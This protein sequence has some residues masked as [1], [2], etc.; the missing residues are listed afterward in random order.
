MESSG[1]LPGESSGTIGVLI[2][3]YR[4]PRDL[5][6]CLDALERQTVAPKEVLV[7]I[8]ADDHET[9]SALDNR[10]SRLLPLR[11][12][13]VIEEGVRAARRVGFDACT[14]DFLAIADDDT[15]AHPDWL[16]RIRDHFLAQPNVA[17]VGGRDRC[18]V[19]GKWDDRQKPRVGEIQWFGRLL[20]YNH[21][22]YGPPRQ[23]Q[24]L[25]GA[26]MSFRMS[27]VG[28]LRVDSRLRGSGAQ[29]HEDSIF[30]VDLRRKGYQIIYDPL[31][32]VDHYEGVRDEPRHYASVLRVTDARQFRDLAYNWSVVISR[33]F[34][35]LQ[36]FVFLIWN[37]L[38]GTRVGPGVLQAV[39]FTPSLGIVSWKRFWLTQQGT[40]ESYRDLI[41]AWWSDGK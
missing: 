31:V 23:V 39:R 5:Q 11:I 18:L 26:N 35:P 33:E 10:A 37:F 27:A 13:T 15:A 6:R 22:G 41:G 36:Q 8:R 4:R 7:V 28:D 38:I 9:R 1:D 3:S 29:P 17:G 12:L 24:I 40:Y 19:G 30:C 21:L 34:P 16:E 14:S 32:L 20:G 25:K 2:C